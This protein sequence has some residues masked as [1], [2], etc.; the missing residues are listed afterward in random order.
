[1]TKVYK[2]L[3]SLDKE[4]IQDTMNKTP[5]KAKQKKKPYKAI[6]PHCSSFSLARISKCFFFYFSYYSPTHILLSSYIY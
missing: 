4:V 3:E 6:K 5:F 1:M 2:Y